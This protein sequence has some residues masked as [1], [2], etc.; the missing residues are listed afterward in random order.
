MNSAISAAIFQK[1]LK[2]SILRSKDHS[3]GSLVNHMQI[4]AQKLVYLSVYL[5]TIVIFPFQ[6]AVGIAILYYVVGISFS[7]GLG[8]I[9]FM[10][11]LDFINGKIFF[12]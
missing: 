7:I 5:S 12:K 1:A 2:I 4:D 10:G 8:I 3:V 11:F 9:I 6:L